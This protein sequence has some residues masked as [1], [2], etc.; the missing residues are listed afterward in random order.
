MAPIAQTK[1]YLTHLSQLIEH[2]DALEKRGFV[3]RFLTDDELL[4]KR[5]CSGCNKS[6]ITFTTLV[7][8]YKSNKSQLFRKYIA[9]ELD[10]RTP[11]QN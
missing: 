9:P 1:V 8:T 5:R 4:L 10:P 2:P 6:N 11:S 3:T 7:R